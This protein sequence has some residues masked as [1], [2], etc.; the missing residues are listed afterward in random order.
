[1]KLNHN[2]LIKN[3]KYKYA[4]P[5]NC[6]NKKNE[7]NIFKLF[8][9]LFILPIT[10]HAN[11]DFTYSITTNN[12]TPYL[13][14]ATIITID[15]NQTNH[16]SVIFFKFFVTKM[17]QYQSKQIKLIENNSYHN[18][19]QKYTYL[20]YPLRTGDIE[21]E[22]SLIQKLTTDDSVAY[23]F[24][25]DRDNVKGL[26]TSDTIIKLPNLK[27]QVKPLPKDTLIVGDFKLDHRLSTNIA[28]AYE[29]ISLNIEIKGRG[30]PPI[31]DNI[32]PKDTSFIQFLSP[33]IVKS[34]IINQDTQITIK[35]ATALSHFQNF[36]LAPLN[37]KAFNPK[38]QKSYI[39]TIPKQDF[40]IIKADKST[41]IDKI[42]SPPPLEID[43]SYIGIALG[44]ILSFGAGF[45]SA[46]LL[47]QKRK[48]KKY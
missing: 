47:F 8:L 43:Y 45:L 17:S 20:I 31:I 14:E 48:S 30:Y 37:L 15:I 1:M 18:T 32:L 39:L 16:K 38:T 22:F 25:G 33:P 40:T 21:I 5:Q 24:S 19:N 34:R 27:L 35:Y 26:V 42:D 4:F 44:Y 9:L 7:L 13:K 28:Q 10:I 11:N 2:K 6:G 41:L 23:S 12:K 36:S 29:P 3:I 46:F